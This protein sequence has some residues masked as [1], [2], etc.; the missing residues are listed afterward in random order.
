MKSF[1]I[2][3]GNALWFCSFQMIVIVLL[4]GK[5]SWHQH[6]RIVKAFEA[7]LVRGKGSRKNNLAELALRFGSDLAD[8]IEQ[9]H[10]NSWLFR[11]FCE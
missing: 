5:R 7:F 1:D 9:N 6:G 3:N 4:G 10:R 2:G 11:G 8:P